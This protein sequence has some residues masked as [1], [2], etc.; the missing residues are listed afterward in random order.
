MILNLAITAAFALVKPSQPVNTRLA[1]SG[2]HAASSAMSRR[3]ALGTIAV[4]AAA[5]SAPAM[6]YDPTE[7][8]KGRK[9]NKIDINSAKPEDYKSLPGVYPRTAQLLATHGPYT[10]V[11]DALKIPELAEEEKAL[12]ETYIPKLTVKPPQ[13]K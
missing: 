8:I 9:I 2:H 5:T 13:R 11:T 7:F 4:S 6:A 12:I 3:T 10:S 1:L